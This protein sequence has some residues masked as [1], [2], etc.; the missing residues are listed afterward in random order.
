[1]AVI[2]EIENEVNSRNQLLERL[3]SDV[4][5]YE[6][7]RQ[8]NEAQAEAVTQTIRS[9]LVRGRRFSNAINGAITFVVALA[10]FVAG[11]FAGRI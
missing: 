9:E 6:Q 3:R 5:Q 4:Q 11:L 10:F 2:S 7:L 1:M 8:L